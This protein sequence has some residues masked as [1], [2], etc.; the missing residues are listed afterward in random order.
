MKKAI[1]FDMDGTLWDSAKQVTDSWNIV[2]E[3]RGIKQITNEDMQSCMGLAMD[4]IFKK[5]FENSDENE[6]KSLQKECETFENE[7]LKTHCGMLYDGLQETLQKLKE[8]MKRLE[9]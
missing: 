8:L 9:K 7:Y 3:K 1:I 5:L 2:L 6:R 4:D